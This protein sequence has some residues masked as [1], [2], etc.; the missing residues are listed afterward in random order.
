MQAATARGAAIF[1][2]KGLAVVLAAAVVT[3]QTGAVSAQDSTWTIASLSQ[4]VAPL[5]HALNERMPLLTQE[6]PE[7]P[8]DDTSVTMR[9][10][11]T[12]LMNIET[13]WSRGIAPSVF[14][15][16]AGT[17][18]GALAT[19]AT[20]HDAGVPIHLFAQVFATEFWPTASTEWSTYQN[21]PVP[22]FPLASP[23]GAYNTLLGTLQSL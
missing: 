14:I 19:A 3:L 16:P 15:P 18:N 12:L 20:L 22:V 23:D 9:S 13:L 21:N 6:L 2:T 4:T 8:T 10:N 17:I 11:G 5:Q 7:I 1:S